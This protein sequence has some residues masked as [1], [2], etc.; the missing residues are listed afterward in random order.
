M[1][2]GSDGR[3]GFSLRLLDGTALKLIAMIS[4][5]SD[6]VGD[7]FFPDQIWMR[8]IGRM[9]LPIF[10]FCTA[11][12]FIHTHDRMK[13]LRRMGIFA[14][15]SEIPFDLVTSGKVLEFTHQNIMVTFFWAILALICFESLRKRETKI[16]KALS[17]AVLAAAMAGSLVFGMDYSFLALGIIFIYFLLSSRAPV[18]NNAAAIAYHAA[19]RNVGIYWFGL[20]GFIPILMYNGRKGRGL[21]WLF[22]CFYPGHLLLIWLIRTLL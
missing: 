10:A 9:A 2:I 1:S 4:M 8:I 16:S 3:Q 20:L 14:L 7:S 11:E 15:I 12:G 6:H 21:K 18:W 5:V 17:W 13:Y 19:L 22:Y